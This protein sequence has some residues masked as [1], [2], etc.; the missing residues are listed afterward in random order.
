MYIFIMV[1]G[2][3]SMEVD[4]HAKYYIYIFFYINTIV[5]NIETLRVSR[6]QFT[7]SI[8]KEALVGHNGQAA[9]GRVQTTES[10]TALPRAK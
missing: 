7:D 2:S 10:P 1:T 6:Y 4:F 9:T 8:G 5:S 3:L